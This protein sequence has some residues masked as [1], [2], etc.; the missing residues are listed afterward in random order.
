MIGP[1]A[2]LSRR[3]P[4]RSLLKERAYIELKR[5]IQEAAFEPGA[6]LSERQ[7]AARL[8]MSKTP[9]KAALERLEAEGFVSVSPQQGIVIR[10][11]SVH[12]IADQYEIRLALEGYVLRALAGR[13]DDA[14]AGRVRE[15]LA[16]HVAAA[17][18]GDT[19]LCVRLDAEFHM[20]F[21]EFL[22]NREI[23]RTMSQLRDKIHRVTLRVF[24]QD[25][26]RLLSSVSE[27]AAIANAVLAGEAET[28][29]RALEDHLRYG[30]EFLLAPRAR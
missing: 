28:A 9:V 25:A 8:G 6:F 10:E 23:V 15:N 18:A 27:H 17:N 19:S 12:E 7:L 11:L 20:L 21:C 5:S 16:A 29:A 2:N 22:G 30:K 4:E 14:G 24:Q 13:I 1:A 3:V 26:G